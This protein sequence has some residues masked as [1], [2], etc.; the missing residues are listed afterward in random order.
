[1]PGDS[2]T[3]APGGVSGFSVLVASVGNVAINRRGRVS[4]FNS[5][6]CDV[7]RSLSETTAR[8]YLPGE[9]QRY[10]LMNADSNGSPIGLLGE[11]IEIDF[12]VI[13]VGQSGLHISITSFAAPTYPGFANPLQYTITMD[14]TVLGPRNFTLTA[15]N[16]KTGADAVTLGGTPQTS[17]LPAVWIGTVFVQWSFAPTVLPIIEII[18]KMNTG[19]AGKVLPPL[20]ATLIGITGTAP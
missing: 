16:G 20:G 6:G 9:Y 7:I 19:I 14:S 17:G 11:L 15:L 8:G 13:Q 4:V 10:L 1:V 2:L 3:A 18:F 12:N 5:H